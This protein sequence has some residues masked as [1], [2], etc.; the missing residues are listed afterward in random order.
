MDGWNQR[1]KGV[2][3]EHQKKDSIET[4]K[5]QTRSSRRIYLNLRFLCLE[6]V[7]VRRNTRGVL[8]A[9]KTSVVTAHVSRAL[10]CPP[11]LLT[12]KVCCRV[13]RIEL[14]CKSHHNHLRCRRR[15]LS[16]LSWLLVVCA[17]R[18]AI[19][20]RLEVRQCENSFISLRTGSRL[21]ECSTLR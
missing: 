19:S 8:H 18:M 7:R 21:A 14:R 16:S 13:T 5:R 3:Q 6:Y 15:P 9:F 11:R 2:N 20:Q 4:T 10:S 17:L 12:P 1:P